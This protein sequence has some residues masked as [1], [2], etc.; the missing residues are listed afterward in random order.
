MKICVVCGHAFDDSD[1]SPTKTCSV[2]NLTPDQA[3]QVFASAHVRDAA[4]QRTFIEDKAFKQIAPPATS[5]SVFTIKQHRLWVFE[6]C[7][8]TKSQLQKILRQL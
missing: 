5:G 2:E 7:S 3:V 8:F 1:N 6:R 4:E